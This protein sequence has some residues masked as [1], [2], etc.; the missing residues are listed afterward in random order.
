[1]T[2]TTTPQAAPIV[3]LSDEDITKLTELIGQMDDE[4]F[5][6]KAKHFIIRHKTALFVGAAVVLAGA[7]GAFAATHK[8]EIHD[9][10]D[11]L[12]EAE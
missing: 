7:A 12:P 4:K 8:D 6:A 3:Q 1:M 10:I 9:V 5:T 2:T 11:A